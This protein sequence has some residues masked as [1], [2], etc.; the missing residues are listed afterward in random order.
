M[1]E[2]QE[3]LE[4]TCKDPRV[5]LRCI[6]PISIIRHPKG[7]TWA[8][9]ACILRQQK[10]TLRVP[11]ITTPEA[12]EAHS[13]GLTERKCLW[14]QPE[15]PVEKICPLIQQ[16]FIKIHLK[17]FTFYIVIYTAFLLQAC[18]IT[19]LNSKAFMVAVIPSRSSWPSAV[20]MQCLNRA[21]RRSVVRACCPGD[22]VLNV[23]YGVVNRS[24]AIG[25]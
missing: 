23:V 13:I 14:G 25:C 19:S 10:Y 16:V 8:W 20:S 9:G 17:S 24:L 1:Q 4:D 7:I 3:P 5:A 11:L 15:V 22:Q 6:T 2:C 21:P 12:L 18:I